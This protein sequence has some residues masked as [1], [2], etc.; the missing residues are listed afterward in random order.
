[1]GDTR[2]RWCVSQIYDDFK[3]LKSVRF[4]E[5]YVKSIC[6]LRHR[7]QLFCSCAVNFTIFTTTTT[8]LLLPHF[9]ILYNSIR[10][11]VVYIVIFV[12]TILTV[13]F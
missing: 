13:T 12:L 7:R 8:V 11:K 4:A 5:N 10:D 2:A 3:T 6:V 9:W 1:M